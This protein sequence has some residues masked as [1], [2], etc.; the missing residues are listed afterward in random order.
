M[1][2]KNTK[3]TEGRDERDFQIVHK[4]DIDT[5]VISLKTAVIQSIN[6]AF[7]GQLQLQEH[8][9]ILPCLPTVTS[10]HR[11]GQEI[12][13]VNVTV[14]QTCRAVAYSEGALKAQ[15]TDLLAQQAGKQVGTSYSLFGNIQESVTMATVTNT[16]RS[17]AGHHPLYGVRRCNKTAEAEQLDPPCVCCHVACFS[18][19]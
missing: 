5:T 2:V 19:G 14:S 1:F 8:V 12:T 11:I 10:D 3:F 13:H 4:S 15:A 18:G 16:T 6:G 7:Q 9:F 17:G